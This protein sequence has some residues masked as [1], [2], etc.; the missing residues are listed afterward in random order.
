M[1]MELDEVK[2]IIQDFFQENTVTII[3]SG[4]SL[5]E[6]IPGMSALARELSSQIPKLLSDPS[7]VDIWSK[8][9][10]NL[11]SGTGLEQALHDTEPTPTIEEHVRKITAQYI[12]KAE[13]E[14]LSDIVRNNKELRFSKYLNHFN[15]RNNGL[16][17]ITTNY[18]RLIEYACEVNGIRVDNLFVGKFFA[19]F[20][21]E[22]S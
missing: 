17:V 15:I 9:A 19:R 2:R 22:Q 21:P 16:A 20:E 8:I 18:D 11:I 5:A 13:A 14:V 7:D 3:G 1:N 6:G 12:G 4:L 10:T